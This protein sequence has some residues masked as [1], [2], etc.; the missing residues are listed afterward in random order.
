MRLMG[1]DYGNKKIGIA[2]S[3]EKGEFSFPYA[4]LE[5]KSGIFGKIRKICRGSNIEKI[6]LGMPLDFKNQP[7]DATAGAQ[8]F[9]SRLEKEIGLSVVFEDERF[10]TKEAER[11]QGR[12]DKID[13]SAA[14][15]ILKSY[16]SRNDML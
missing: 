12:T 4:V 6:I 8:E 1:V 2:L 9:K 10:S 16:I 13:A 5:N 14:A 11:I 7:T 3:D 15:L